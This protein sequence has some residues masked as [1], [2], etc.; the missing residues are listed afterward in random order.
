MRFV[1]EKAEKGEVFLR[2]LRFSLVSIIPSMLH[3]YLYINVLLITRTKGRS[4]GTR[5][6][7]NALS[8]I[9]E[10]RTKATLTEYLRG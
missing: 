5:H 4:L 6:E 8:E 7:I 1:V 2:V 9:G 3:N 10:Q